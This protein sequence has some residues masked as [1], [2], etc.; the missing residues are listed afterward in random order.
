MNVEE[1]F[2]KEFKKYVEYKEHIINGANYINDARISQ[3][4]HCI[5]TNEAIRRDESMCMQYNFLKGLDLG[6]QKDEKGNVSFVEFL[7]R[8][9]PPSFTLV[10]TEDIVDYCLIKGITDPYFSR[11]NK[12]TVILR[13]RISYTKRITGTDGK[14]LQDSESNIMT[15]DVDIPQGSRVVLSH[16]SIRLKNYTVDEHGRQCRTKLPDGFGYIDYVDTATGRKYL[17]YVPKEYIFPM[18]LN[19]MV[20]TTSRLTA[21]YY[22]GRRYFFN[23]GVS[24]AYLYVVPY[25]ASILK[26][27]N[28]VFCLKASDDFEQEIQ[29]L[30]GYWQSC[31]G[32][33][34]LARPAILYPLEPLQLQ[35]TMG[36]SG[37]GDCNL[38]YQTLPQPE[39]D[40]YTVIT[41]SLAARDID[42]TDGLI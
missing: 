34:G 41:E 4:M 42:Q 32:T 3:I 6:C 13:P 11:L 19:A 20:L 1:L 39:R 28:V 37:S 30:E 33:N 31:V 29:T 21:R 40:P 16:V 26:P 36:Y 12:T 15:R 10:G 2:V 22:W 17:Y 38:A 8:A 25:T 9:L 18:N 5:P 24:S 7:R 14:F 35:S 27:N 23:R